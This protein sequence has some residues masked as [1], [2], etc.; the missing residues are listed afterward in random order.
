MN[1]TSYIVDSPLNYK[2]NSYLNVF[3]K[4]GLEDDF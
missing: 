4:K 3:Y 1:T 2:S